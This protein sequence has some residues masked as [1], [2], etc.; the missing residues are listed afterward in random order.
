VEMSTIERIDHHINTIQQGSSGNTKVFAMA[1]VNSLISNLRNFYDSP[2]CLKI[3]CERYIETV[4]SWAQK[5]KEILHRYEHETNNWSAATHASAIKS[6]IKDLTKNPKSRCQCETGWLWVIEE[7]SEA[8]KKGHSPHTA[9]DMEVE[10]SAGA[11][12]RSTRMLK[13]ARW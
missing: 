4:S 5:F 8:Q 1:A 2:T 11:M 7:L 9:D 6:V 3:V 10:S 13:R 12:S